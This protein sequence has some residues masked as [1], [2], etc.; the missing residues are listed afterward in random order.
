MVVGV[1]WF[2]STRMPHF[3]LPSPQATLSALLTERYNWPRH[4]GV[5]AA[6]VFGGFALATAVGGALAVLF[7]WLPLL[8]RAGMP[9]LVTTNMIPKV[10][11]EPL[12]IVWLG[13]GIGPNIVITFAICFFP[14]VINTAR[15]LKEVEPD[16]VD[17]VRVLRASRRQI[18]A[19]IQLPSALPFIF[20]GMRVASVL[21]VAGAIVGEF[22]GSERGLGYVMM[23]LQ[24]TMDTAGMFAGLVLI[25]LIGVALYGLVVLLER[26]F[27]ATDA[28]VS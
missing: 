16:L 7:S 10:A 23:S 17:L 2:A 27:L 3:I 19:K 11:M 9:L 4:L 6:E 1:W 24:A 21:A 26:Y 15:G 22:I 8:N 12:F 13:Y 14:I 18:F 25:T 28:R 20:S 5:T